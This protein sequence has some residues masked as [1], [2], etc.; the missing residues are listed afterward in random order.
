MLM[1]G[2]SF[3]YSLS[4]NITWHLFPLFPL[5]FPGI[6]KEMFQNF[7]NQVEKKDFSI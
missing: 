1:T 4:N 2:F 3:N 5:F 7:D 6:G